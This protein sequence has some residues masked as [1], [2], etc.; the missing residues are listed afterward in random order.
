MTVS[1]TTAGRRNAHLEHENL[2]RGARP[3]SHFHPESA[4]WSRSVGV[5]RPDVPIGRLGPPSRGRNRLRARGV[6]REA[7]G[8][9][10]AVQRPGRRTCPHPQGE[11][12]LHPLWG[13]QEGDDSPQL[14]ASRS[15]DGASQHSQGSGGFH[16]RLQG[17]WEAQAM[18]T[19]GVGGVP[20]EGWPSTS[21]P[22]GS[23]LSS[24]VDL[25]G[26]TSPPPSSI[27]CEV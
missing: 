26:H 13:E 14:G 24:P 22:R 4:E 18:I 11:R 17:L 25:V 8:P 3:P 2:P 9:R 27:P 12:R 10:E 7:G 6:V 16:L 5:G 21:H 23:E 19:K 15:R 20:T 1:I